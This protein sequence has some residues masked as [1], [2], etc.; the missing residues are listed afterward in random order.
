MAKGSKSTKAS[1]KVP[2]DGYIAPSDP[3][4]VLQ[5]INP[6][7]PAMPDVQVVPPPPAANGH[8]VVPPAPG[9]VPPLVP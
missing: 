7:M 8:V 4:N 2:R 5:N 1:R 9:P 6:Q 3:A